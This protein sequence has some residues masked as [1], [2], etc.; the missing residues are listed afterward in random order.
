MK[1]QTNKLG[2]T[3][4]GIGSNIDPIKNIQS[5]LNLL[6]KELSITC[7]ASIWQTPAVGSLGPDYLNTALLIND[8]PRLDIL[9]KEVLSKVE[10][11][12]G[13]VRTL[14]KY[15]DR[16]IDLDLLIYR[17]KCLDDDLWKQAHVAIPAAELLP[18][19]SNQI[20]GEDLSAISERFK[21]KV[22]FILREDLA[23]SF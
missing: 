9:K 6:A 23:F 1:E 11:S 13:R 10:L 17:G 18:D 22:N 19:Y 2:D 14:D 15:A 8:P 21:L 3:L 7:L 20:T 5:A 16:S 12:L 4:I